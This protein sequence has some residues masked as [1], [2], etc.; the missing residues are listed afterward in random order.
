VDRQL[1]VSPEGY[2]LSRTGSVTLRRSS[3]RIIRAH[4]RLRRRAGEFRRKRIRLQRETRERRGLSQRVGRPRWGCWTQG[5]PHS[6]PG[7]A[8]RIAE[9][10]NPAEMGHSML[11]PYIENGDLGS[12]FVE[13]AFVI[14]FVGGDYVVGAEFFLGVDARDFAHFAAAVAAGE[15]FDG[16]A[17]GFFHVA[18][19]H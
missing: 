18:G 7:L 15:D 19:L 11:R 8:P 10:I 3:A 13:D 14:G 6:F 5:G 17:G 2:L 12:G 16:V 1:T 9:R 4:G